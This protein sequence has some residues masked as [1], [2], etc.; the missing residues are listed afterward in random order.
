MLVAAQGDIGGAE[1]VLLHLLEQ[2]PVGEAVVCA[3]ADSE[4]ARAVASIGHPVRHLELPKLVN[5]ESAW[6]YAG[7]Y[8]RALKSLVAVLRTERASVVHGFASFTVKIVIPASA[9][10]GVPAV[11]GVHEITTPASIGRLRSAAQRLLSAPRTASFVAV[12]SYVADSLISSGY[13]AARVHVVHNGIARPVPRLPIDEARAAIGLEPEGIV[14]LV[15]ARLSW[16]KGVH[17][18]I[19]AFARYSGRDSPPARLLVVGGPAEPGDERY[20]DSLHAQ[21][22]SLGLDHL[23]HFFGPRSDVE[24][25]YDACDVVLVPSV[26]PDPFPTVVLEAGLAGRAAVVTAMGGAREAVVDGVT[27]IVSEPTPEG[28][29]SAMAR[30]VEAAWHVGAGEAALAHVKSTFDLAAFAA[31]IRDQWR[32]AAGDR[33]PEAPIRGRTPPRAR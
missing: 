28:F 29:A 2:V 8:F 30:S 1:R 26:E 27:G 12:S 20:R 14:F 17:V 9:I 32:V 24:R 22:R 5:S 23:V 25:F 4:L 13:P 11:I 7:D 3:P 6:S 31:A 18:A 21:V 10:A 16:W 33:A 19:D 15:V